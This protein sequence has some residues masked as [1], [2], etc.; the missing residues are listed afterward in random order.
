MN[1]I[2][3]KQN[4]HLLIDSIEN[5]KLLINFYN[6]IKKRSSTKEGQLWNKLTNQEQEELLLSLEESKNIENLVS[7]N[8]MKKK[9]EKWL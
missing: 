8:E 6:L 4:F 7:H 2:E 5:E 3:L 9:Y 1:T